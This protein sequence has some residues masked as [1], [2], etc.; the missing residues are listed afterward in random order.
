LLTQ[1]AP[2]PLPAHTFLSRFGFACLIPTVGLFTQALQRSKI[3]S[4]GFFFPSQ[5][6]N[7]TLSP[8]PTLKLFFTLVMMVLL[9]ENGGI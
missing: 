8:D 5:P 4:Y 3:L 7:N 1:H 2:S 6:L 9:I